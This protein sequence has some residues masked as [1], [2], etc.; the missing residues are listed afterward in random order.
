VSPMHDAAR[1]CF[2]ER[3]PN[4][5]IAPRARAEALGTLLVVAAAQASALTADSLSAEAAS[6]RQDGAETR[7]HRCVAR[8]P[9]QSNAVGLLC[10][11]GLITLR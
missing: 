3:D 10:Q 2:F 6:V 11:V 1:T 7:R 5:F 8:R 9:N 4:A